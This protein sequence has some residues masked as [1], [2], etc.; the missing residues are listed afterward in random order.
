M[1]NNPTTWDVSLALSL[2]TTEGSLNPQ[3]R[4]YIEGVLGNYTQSSQLP[5]P[6]ALSPAAGWSLLHRLPRLAKALTMACAL[7][8]EATLCQS[9]GMGGA[10]Q[11]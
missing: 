7:S 5:P 11:D 8:L 4:L 2:C 9:L 10:P 1:N 6:S 3:S